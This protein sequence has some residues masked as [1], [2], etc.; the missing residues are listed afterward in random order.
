MKVLTGHLLITRVFTHPESGERRLLVEDYHGR[1]NLQVHDS[2]SSRRLNKLGN[3][4]NFKDVPPNR[5]VRIYDNFVS[6]LGALEIR[7]AA[8]PPS[9]LHEETLK[10][11]QESASFNVLD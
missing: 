10:W 8:S 5:V 1:H 7:A 3:L 6:S 4:L 11:K 2:Y 9:K